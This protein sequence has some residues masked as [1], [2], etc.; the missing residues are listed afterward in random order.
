MVKVKGN[1]K[2]NIWLNDEQ[3]TKLREASE[4]TGVPMSKIF[5]DAI[6][7]ELERI[8]PLIEAAKKPK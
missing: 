3:L 4:T 8:K 5:R 6:D 7:R 2:L 1:T